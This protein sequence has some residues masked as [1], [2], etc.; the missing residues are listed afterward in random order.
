[1]NSNFEL[2]EVLLSLNESSVEKSSSYKGKVSE[3]NTS[4]ECLILNELPEHLKVCLS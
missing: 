2:K 3:V 1:M 4:L